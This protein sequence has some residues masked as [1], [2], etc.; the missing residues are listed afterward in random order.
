MFVSNEAVVK[1]MFQQ[2][3]LNRNKDVGAYNEYKLAGRTGLTENDVS[4]FFDNAQVK[5]L[6]ICK[7]SFQS[8]FRSLCN[9][10]SM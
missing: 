1:V 2:S 3:R 4:E 8:F 7:H 10:I 5:C 6:K 9:N